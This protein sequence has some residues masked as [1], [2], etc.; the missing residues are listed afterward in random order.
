MELR[1]SIYTAFIEWKKQ[2]K[3]L[4]LLVTG[5]RQVGKTHAIRQFGNAEYKCF[6]EINFVETP[7]AMSI[8]AGDLDANTLIASL[9]AFSNNPLIPRKTL[10][11]L[12]EIQECPRA[13]TAMKFLV[14]DGRFDYIASGSLLGVQYKDVPSYPVGY[15]MHTRMY[16]LSLEEFYWASG[17]QDEILKLVKDC[18]KD[19]QP[20]PSAVHERLLKGF[21]QYTI[22]GG[23]PAAVVAFFETQDTKTVQEIQRAIL[24]LY[25]Q[26]I[27]KYG[28]N[29]THIRRIFESIPA[30]L[31]KKNKRFK[32]SDL[33]KTARMERYESDFMWL[34]DA[35]VALPC[36]NVS[37]PI[38]PLSINEQRNLFKLFLCDIGL[39]SSQM[40]SKVRLEFLQGELSA[41][42]GSILENAIAQEMVAHDIQLRY[43][44]KT[45]Y[46]EV[47]FLLSTSEGVIPIEA[48]SGN[49]YK[50][51]KALTNIMNVSEWK[52]D[53]AIVLCKGNVS[54][55]GD[56]TYLPWY[57]AMLFDRD[58]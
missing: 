32:L 25:K 31:D 42:W 24:D 47:D 30:E 2:P 45:K 19:K 36:Y 52:I 55:I 11:F 7:S 58:E 34:I 22:T 51:H 54:T 28:S 1:R 21:S 49:D 9:T 3:R 48:K 17:F 50:A 57:A 18:I 16:P 5:A 26:D 23:M 10:V 35:G 6:L 46:G 8:F 27:S 29:K 53:E 39:L 41:N 33:S 13:R 44:D 38:E 40:P 12:D 56:V 37:A 15:E 20:I 43:F 14:E 4:A